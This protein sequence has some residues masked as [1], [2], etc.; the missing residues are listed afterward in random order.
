M[1]Y[2]AT[3]P[4]QLQAMEYARA[5]TRS[6]IPSRM[7]PRPRALEA[8]CGTAVRF[9]SRQPGGYPADAG[10]GQNAVSGGAGQL[11]ARSAKKHKGGV[12]PANRGAS[13][14]VGLPCG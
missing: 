14:L 3:F 5:L 13:P 1:E 8:S 7:M 9:S 12:Y 11:L 6:G 2:L 10:P 4:N